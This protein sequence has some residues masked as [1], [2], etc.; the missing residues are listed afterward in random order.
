[1]R[2]LL[3][4]LLLAVPALAQEP[5][6]LTVRAV[7]LNAWGLPFGLAADREARVRALG[8]ALAALRPD[9]VCLPEAWLSGHAQALGAAVGNAGLGNSR[10]FPSRR[11][12]SGLFVAS[13]WPIADAAFTTFTLSGKPHKP[14]H[15]DWYGAKGLARVLLDTP[16]GPLAVA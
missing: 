8:P 9:A 13:R 12:G 6:E 10:N 3:L 1:M 15:A 2:A 4:A 14:W 11:W 7:T 5:R 16:V